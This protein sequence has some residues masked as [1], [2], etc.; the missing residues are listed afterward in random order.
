MA[1]FWLTMSL[2]YTGLSEHRQDTR[3][4]SMVEKYLSYVQAERD[5][6][7]PEGRMLY[8]TEHETLWFDM[9]ETQRDEAI[10]LG[11]ERGLLR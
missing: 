1:L 2:P 6:K 5:A 3:R 4:P 8:R 10:R 11:R 7:T 9:T